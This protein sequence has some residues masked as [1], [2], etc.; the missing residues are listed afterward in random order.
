MQSTRSRSIGLD[1]GRGRDPCPAR[2]MHG[3]AQVV[4]RRPRPRRGVVQCRRRRGARPGR[5]ERRRQEHADQGH[6]RPHPAG[7]RHHPDQR[8][9]AGPD[10]TR[11]RPCA[12][13]PHGVPGADAAALDDRGGEPA[14]RPRAAWPA[15]ADQPSPHGPRGGR[16]AGP[17]GDRAYR[18]PGPGRRDLAG[19]APDHRDRAGHQQRAGHPAARRADLLA[20]RARGPLAVRADRP[21][22]RTRDLHHL[23]L[24]PVARDPQRR[25]PDH[26]VPRRPRCRHLRGDRRDRRHHPDDRQACRGALPGGPAVGPQR[27]RAGGQGRS[28]AG[29]WTGSASRCT[30]ARSWASAAWPATAIASCSS[31]CS[32]PSAWPAG[33]CWSMASPC[34]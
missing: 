13:H 23:H 1:G 31:R 5:R 21:A 7:R 14:D 4:R 10:F 3:P 28:W 16:A 34:G 17:D 24:A 25:R 27:Q 18:P 30:A 19:R 22:A 12:R 20:G 8:A 15:G 32:A 2:R 11:E 33:R 29:A 9:S 26:R 6:R